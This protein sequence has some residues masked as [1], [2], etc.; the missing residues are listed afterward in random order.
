MIKLVFTIIAFQN[1]DSIALSDH[2]KYLD[3]HFL[4][5]TLHYLHRSNKRYIKLLQTNEL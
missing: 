2:K 3:Q 5:Y 1:K 4:K